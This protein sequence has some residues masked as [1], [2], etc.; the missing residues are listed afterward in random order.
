MLQRDLAQGSQDIYYILELGNDLI[1]GREGADGANFVRQQLDSI[2]A[3][4]QDINLQ[5][6]ERQRCLE[7]SIAKGFHRDVTALQKWLENADKSVD[8]FLRRNPSE[9]EV[10][11]YIQVNHLF[12][13]L[14]LHLLT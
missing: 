4:W 3:K 2:S 5:A 14:F 10:D 8:S 6:T 12:S 13:Y 1:N 7:E 9:L 11:R